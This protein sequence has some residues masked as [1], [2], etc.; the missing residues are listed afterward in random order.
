MEKQGRLEVGKYNSK[1]EQKSKEKQPDQANKND[2][3]RG[4]NPGDQNTR[5]REEY[6]NNFPK[7][8]NNFSR[9]E[10]TSQDD[11]T[12]KQGGQSVNTTT[13]HINKQQYG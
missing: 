2:K 10:T 4:G 3:Q 7:I 5:A 13:R 8:S 6:H 1:K 9:Y 12:N 11:K